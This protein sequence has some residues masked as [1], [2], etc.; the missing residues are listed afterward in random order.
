MN[1][2]LAGQPV[3]CLTF[4]EMAGSESSAEQ[5]AAA[6]SPSASGQVSSEKKQV[7]AL[8]RK[9]INSSF[10]ALIS[11]M[12]A[13]V[14]RKL[15]PYRQSKLTSFLQHHSQV[16][17]PRPGSKRPF[18]GRL[19]MVVCVEGVASDMREIEASLKFLAK[20]VPKVEARP[21]SS[22]R[23]HKR[24]SSFVPSSPAAS[25]VG[26]RTYS[27]AGTA[28]P[29]EVHFG[30]PNSPDTELNGTIRQ[31]HSPYT[32]DTIGTEHSAFSSPNL[33]RIISSQNSPRQQLRL[34]F[35]VASQLAS[36]LNSAELSGYKEQLLQQKSLVKRHE[37]SDS[38]LKLVLQ[39]EISRAQGLEEELQQERM[40]NVKLTTQ[41]EDLSK[42]KE[43]HAEL[44]TKHA[45]LLEGNAGLESA[46]KMTYKNAEGAMDGLPLSLAKSLKVKEA[47][48]ADFKKENAELKRQLSLKQTEMVELELSHT[49][50]Q[51]QIS[52]RRDQAN[53]ITSR[54]NSFSSQKHSLSPTPATRGILT[55]T[56]AEHPTV[57]LPDVSLPKPEFD[58]SWRETSVHVGSAA[59]HNSEV[60]GVPAVT[61]DIR[62]L[63]MTN[64]QRA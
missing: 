17:S 50:M 35:D 39:R 53:P 19:T 7:L 21:K 44:Q 30:S 51:L 13:I 1:V 31:P 22:Q 20:L 59:D 41:H 34:H 23:L 46:L 36:D 16:T 25:S 63:S 14:T 26:G 2:S 55:P 64:F 42:L 12:D 38:L 15:V 33:T 3:S 40:A 29:L 56:N 57:Y 4:I 37:D 58:S 6:Y 54:S 5:K 52:T 27:D 32:M 60:G 28:L 9:A 10:L 45:K 61:F 24:M 8:E 62:H 18:V 49:Q 43:Q 47:E 48:N 11:V